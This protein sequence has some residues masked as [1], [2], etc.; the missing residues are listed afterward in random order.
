L[1]FFV[2]CVKFHDDGIL[3]KNNQLIK[4]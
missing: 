3:Q 4:V 2:A 1:P